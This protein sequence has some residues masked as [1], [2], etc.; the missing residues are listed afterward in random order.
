MQVKG[1]PL[2]FSSDEELVDLSLPS[3]SFYLRNSCFL[4]TTLTLTEFKAS[5]G[6]KRPISINCIC[7][8]GCLENEDPE[9]EDLR[10]RKLR[11]PTKSWKTKTQ[12]PKTLEK[13]W[14]RR[15]R[16]LRPL[17][18]SWK[19]KTQTPYQKLENEDPES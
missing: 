5:I 2:L 9:N 3:S 19:T 10:P 8:H 6:S 13:S 15:P 4:Q 18:K 17:T 16:K 7:I 12:K 11:P 1:H 14:K